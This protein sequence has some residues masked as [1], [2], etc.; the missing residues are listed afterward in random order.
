MNN[1]IVTMTG[2]G[3]GALSWWLSHV[4]SGKFEP[5]DSAVGFFAT[6]LVLVPAAA[7]MGYKRGILSSIALVAGGYL[8]LNGYAYA[9]GGAEHRAWAL[10]GAITTIALV[11]IPSVAGLLGGVAGRLVV[12]LRA[13]RQ[14]G[15][16]P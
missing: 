6:Q 16:R 15:T 9:L 12:K 1:L 14:S 4:V 10:L 5:F 8:G 13:A 11:A 7:V 2:A 3:L